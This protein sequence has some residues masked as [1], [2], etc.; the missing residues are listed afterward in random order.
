MLGNYLISTHNWFY[1][2]DGRRYHA[3]WGEVKLFL[4]D[5]G[6]IIIGDM[7]IQSD[8]VAFAIKCTDKPNTGD[9][10]DTL[11]SEVG[12]STFTRPTEIWIATP[13]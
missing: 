10:E 11:Y 2:P 7:I 5:V 8:E 1:A 4:K 12:I 9:I 6:T 3:V 13:L